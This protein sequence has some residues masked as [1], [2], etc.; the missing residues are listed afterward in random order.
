[1]AERYPDY[2]RRL[3][4]LLEVCRNL[5]ANLELGPLLQ[6]IIEIASDLTTS[7]NSFVLLYDKEKKYLQVTAA[8]FYLLDSLRTVG[9]PL[10]RSLAGKAFQTGESLVFRENEA[11]EPFVDSMEWERKNNALC[12]V[13]VPL[14][15]KGE[16]IGV[17]ESMN[18]IK[19]QNYSEEDILFLDTLATQAA[20]AIQNQQLI[21]S[22]QNAYRKMM[23]L[24]RM[25][26]DFIAIASHELRTPLG[27]IMGHTAF[28][29]E[30]ATPE[31]R[32]DVDIIS[33][34]AEKLRD[35]I[36]EIDDIDTLTSGMTKMKKESVS[37]SQV[38]QQVVEPFLK[39]AGQRKIRLSVES[40]Q[41]NLTVE[42][43]PEKISMALRNLVKNAITFTNPDGM[44]KVTAEQ[45]PGYVKVAVLDNGIGI[46]EG[47]QEKIFQRFYQVEKHLTRK[48]GGI[49][50]GLSIAKEMVEMHGGKIWVESVEG[51]G[52]R[53]TFILPMNAAQV[54]AAEKV[55][56][57]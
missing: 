35:L 41:A 18:K 19:G 29:S 12:A 52:S 51:K 43:D 31:Q 6:A 23:E 32:A 45:L 16:R 34:N 25:K 42:G 1:M 55:F 57:Q 21:Q 40:K 27:L 22:A 54:T 44:V 36:A 17:I 2:T 47:E 13:A 30:T 28:L 38:I 3:E 5:T 50:L 46:P 33:R 11:R 8:P 49:G 9:V 53:F 37:L 4:R 56:A 10:D 14:I 39:E 20:T 48:H 24:D 7:E 15:Y 26:S